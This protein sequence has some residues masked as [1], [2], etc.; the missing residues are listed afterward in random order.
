MINFSFRFGKEAC[1]N[2]VNFLANLMYIQGLY[3]SQEWSQ[4]NG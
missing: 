2:G 3:L 4:A 1:E